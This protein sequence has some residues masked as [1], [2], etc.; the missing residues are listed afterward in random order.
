MTKLHMKGFVLQL[1]HMTKGGMWDY[2]ITRR[3][4][5]EYQKEASSYWK[6]NVRLMLADLYSSGMVIRL[7]EVIDDG[8]HV[9]R[10]KLLHKYSL[11]QFGL[12]RMA[13]T[14]LA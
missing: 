3:L 9:G 5:K 2:E 11:S 13:E 10:G 14:G 4:V 6:G 12:T 7:E 8:S 1:L